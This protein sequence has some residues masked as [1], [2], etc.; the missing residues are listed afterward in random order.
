MKYAFFGSPRFAEVILE[1]LIKAG[2]RPGVVVCNPDRRVGRKQV[3]ASPPVKARIMKYELGIRGKIKILQPET[4]DSQFHNSLSM[5]HN[6]APFDFFLVAAYA[7]IIP[8]TIIEIPRLG[9][10][11]V[12]P[13][14]L[15]KYRGAT[16]IQSVI[17][18]G[19]EKTGTT[20]F[21]LD[22]KVDHGPILAQ[23]VMPAQAGIQTGSQIKF[24]MTY[25]S[26][27]EKL[28]ELSGELLVETLPK[29]AEG[30]IK[31]AA[32]NEA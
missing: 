29:F 14:L 20:P 23:A 3:L 12:H 10:I 17:L 22:E 21:M 26:L 16:P 27:M 30:K 4:L 31:L 6:S 24:G 2:M 9:A 28:A 8:R 7:K 11:G 1:K 19:E 15:P 18:A 5:I 25:E 13:S 32:Q